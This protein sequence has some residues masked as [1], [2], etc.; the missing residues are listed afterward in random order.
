M[1]FFKRREIWVP[2]Y[3]GFFLMCLVFFCT[4]LFA[5]QNIAKFL[6]YDN[7]VRGDYLIVEGWLDQQA[8]LEAVSLFRQ[9][10]YQYMITTGSSIKSGDRKVFTNYA[11]RATKFMIKSGIDTT[12]IIT[13]PTPES[14]QDRTFLS[15]VMV[16]NW[17]LDNH[18]FTSSLD[19]FSAHVHARRTHLLYQ[20]AFKNQTRIG[21]I[22]AKPHRF[23]LMHW[24]RTSFGAKSVISELAGFIWVKCC[25]SSG[26]YQSHQEMWGNYTPD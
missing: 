6:A 4:V 16:R 3:L 23:E 20:M 1:I 14:A 5:L 21:I 12:K 19:I 11:E 24:W 2:T 10:G 18:I 25:F 22:A 26:K 8:F 9:E 15:A 17:M 13:L 7:P